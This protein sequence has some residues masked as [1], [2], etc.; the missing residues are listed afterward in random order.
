MGIDDGIVRRRQEG[1][2]E[3]EEEEVGEEEVRAIL[4]F[5]ATAIEVV[6]GVGVGIEGDGLGR[7]LNYALQTPKCESTEMSL[8]L[9][10][11]PLQW[12]LH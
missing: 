5:R 6:A 4:A 8:G 10:E 12:H 2:A 7:G 11:I 3:E 1:A 9:S